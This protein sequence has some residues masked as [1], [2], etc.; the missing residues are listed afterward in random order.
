LVRSLFLLIRK[1][2]CL[3]GFCSNVV[4]RKLL[5]YHFWGLRESPSRVAASISAIIVVLST[6]YSTREGGACF[7]GYVASDTM[8]SLIF[9]PRL[10]VEILAHHAASVLLSIVGLSIF[11]EIPALNPLGR[12]LL[13]MEV[14]NPCTHAL[15]LT[16]RERELAALKPT[17]FLQA[18]TTLLLFFWYRVVASAQV[19]FHTL[20]WM[21]SESKIEILV[22]LVLVATISTLQVYWFYRLCALTLKEHR[23]IS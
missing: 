23:K 1:F 17:L 8:C 7:L 13:L 3:F 15:W 18:F 19:T 22:P 14:V 2:F 4:V 11:D 21:L 6:L 5:S 16:S 10:K 20:T 9:G 12:K